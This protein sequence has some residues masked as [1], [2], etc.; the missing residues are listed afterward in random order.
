MT[1]LSEQ[2]PEWLFKSMQDLYGFTAAEILTS[3]SSAFWH[4][5][6]SWPF[7]SETISHIFVFKVWDFNVLSLCSSGD[8]NHA[9]VPPLCL[10]SID[11]FH[12]PHTDGHD[13]L[14]QWKINKVKKEERKKCCSG[15]VLIIKSNFKWI[16]A[17]QREKVSVT[18]WI[19]N[20]KSYKISEIYHSFITLIKSFFF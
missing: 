19:L 16:R 7:T 13:F 11:C 5:I 10:L 8:Q 6:I 15:T 9:S 18:K 17:D 20:F 14:T 1:F 12:C 2:I 3:L 4:F